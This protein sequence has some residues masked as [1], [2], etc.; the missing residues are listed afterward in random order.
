MHQGTNQG[1]LN[2]P[3]GMGGL[4]VRRARIIRAMRVPSRARATF[5]EPADGPHARL[6]MDTPRIGFS[7]EKLKDNTQIHGLTTLFI[8][9]CVAFFGQISRQYVEWP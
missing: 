2:D 4:A 3:A 1:A 8:H 7:P 9:Q 6:S 5:I